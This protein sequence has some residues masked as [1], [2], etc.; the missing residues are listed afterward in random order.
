MGSGFKVRE[1]LR[2]GWRDVRRAGRPEG[3]LGSAG[4]GFRLDARGLLSPRGRIL[5]GHGP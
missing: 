5:A 1:G 3:L 2:D 4:S